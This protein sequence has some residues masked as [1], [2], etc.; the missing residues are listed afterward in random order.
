[1]AGKAAVSYMA[2]IRKAADRVDTTSHAVVV[3]DAIRSIEFFLD[4]LKTEMAKMSQL[5]DLTSKD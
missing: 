2:A 4:K 5:E 1:L 3:E